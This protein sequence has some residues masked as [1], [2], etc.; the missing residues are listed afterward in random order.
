MRTAKSWL[1][2]LTLPKLHRLATALGTPCSGTKT[3]R[4]DG[5]KQALTD[6]NQHGTE[7]GHISLLSIDMGIRN[8]AFAHLQAPF[9]RNDSKGGALYGQ[10]TLTAWRKTAVSVPPDALDLSLLGPGTTQ[11]T[12]S[13][14]AKSSKS[15][16][17][18]FEPKEFAEHAYTLCNQLLEAYTPTHILIERQ[19][20]RSGGQSAVLEWAI[21]VGVF[22][23][24]L[25]SAFAAISR[26]RNLDLV[27]EP[28]Q[29]PQVNRY[30]LGDNG[31]IPELTQAKLT[32]REV[33]RAKID[34]VG[35]ML[36]GKTLEMRIGKD[37][38]PLVDEF[39]A[40]CKKA[41]KK[42]LRGEPAKEILKLDDLSDSLLQGLAFLHWQNHRDRVAVLGRDAVDM[43]SGAII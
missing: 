17:E 28:M 4:I 34:V 23:G 31:S 16:K 37:A 30:W 19:R 1:E 21:R 27:I 39:V 15:A 35:K 5:I 18:S 2:E 9:L 6:I 12:A 25:Y 36:Q 7:K 13:D 8:L 41:S 42:T 14:N 32:G 33:K 20:F 22:E 43:E 11:A 26:E 40:R 24:M 29:P 3:A 10:P 38:K